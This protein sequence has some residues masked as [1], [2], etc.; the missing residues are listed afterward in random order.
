MH[1]IYNQEEDRK[2]FEQKLRYPVLN[3]VFVQEKF[4]HLQSIIYVQRKD[5][6]IV[7]VII[8]YYNARAHLEHI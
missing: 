4:F 8:V 1:Y 2:S 7:L 5:E 6:Q 3:P